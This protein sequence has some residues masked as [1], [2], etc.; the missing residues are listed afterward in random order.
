MIIFINDKEYDITDFV[1][2]H[3]GGSEVFENGQDMTEQFNDVGHS[4]EAIKMLD[5]FLIQ[6]END[7]E[8]IEEDNLDTEISSESLNDIIEKDNK[9]IKKTPPPYS[10]IFLLSIFIGFISTILY[11]FVV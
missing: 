11:C 5:T 8:E 7:D 9:I 2:E 1:D 10:I 4:I 6:K 3:P